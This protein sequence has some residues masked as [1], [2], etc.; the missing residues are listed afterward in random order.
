MFPLCCFFV[1]HAYTVQQT[2]NSTHKMSQTWRH[3][4]FQSLLLTANTTNTDVEYQWLCCFAWWTE[5]NWQKQVHTTT[6]IVQSNSLH[7]GLSRR[8]FAVWGKRL[9]YHTGYIYFYVVVMATEDV[10]LKIKSVT[11]LD[12]KIQVRKCLGVPFAIQQ[13]WTVQEAILSC[14]TVGNTGP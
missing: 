12:L 4:C 7:F 6:K 3:T 10:H 5:T 8:A 14:W 9:V 2:N 13:W 11:H 1:W